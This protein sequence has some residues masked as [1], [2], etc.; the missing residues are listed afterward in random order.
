VINEILNSP[1]FGV[2]LGG[3]AT[4][5]I[6]T[7]IVAL[8]KTKKDDQALSVLGVVLSTLTGTFGLSKTK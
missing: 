4:N 2:F 5:G 6:F 3:F 8:T 7:Q 1:W